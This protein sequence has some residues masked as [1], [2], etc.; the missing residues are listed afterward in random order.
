MKRNGAAIAERNGHARASASPA[1]P[2]KRCAVYCR[3]SVEERHAT[4]FGSIDAQRE[5]CEAFI[6]SQ[7]SLGWTPVAARYEDEGFTGANTD[8]PAL[9]RLL[10]DVEGGRVDVVVVYKIDRLSRSIGDFVRLSELFDRHDVAFVSVTQQFNTS[11]SVGRLTL[12]LLSV[13]AQ[14]E[15]ETISERTRDKMRAARRRGKYVGGA[16]I[17]GYDRHPEGR[18]LVVNAEEAERVRALFDLYIETKSL[19]EVVGIANERGWT[20][21]TWTSKKDRVVK[22][23]R[24]HTKGLRALLSN[25]AYVGKVRFGG[26]TFAAEH[27]GIVTEDVFD[28]AQALLAANGTTGGGAARNKHSALLKGLLR[29]TACDRAMLPTHTT[30]GGRRYEYYVCERARDEGWKACPSPSVPAIEIERLVVGQIRAIGKDPA[31]VA[32]TLDAARSQ[33]LNA[34]IDADELRRVLGLWDDVWAALLPKEQARVLALLVQRVGYDGAA[35][36]V[37]V[38]FHPTGIAALAAEVR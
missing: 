8:R 37:A 31:V 35:G 36:N 16:L 29:C 19:V 14:F 5:A 32:A 23:R 25:H 28:K 18:R 17:L 24:F 38:A 15:R 20:T 2:T 22:G 26:E 4:D 34:P 9:A 30:K 6:K 1:V 3:K 27:E 12:N 11:T 21:K 13:F 7:Q 33:E 10:A